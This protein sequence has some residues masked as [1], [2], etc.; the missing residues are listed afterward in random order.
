[1]RRLARIGK[2]LAPCGC[3]GRAS[4]VNRDGVAGAG[5]M[6][7]HG[8]A[9]DAKAQEGHMLR[10]SGFVGFCVQAAHGCLCGEVGKLFKLEIVHQI[11]ILGETC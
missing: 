9:H 3:F 10:G 6:A 5:Q 7:C 4:V 2:L 11:E 1:M 8:I